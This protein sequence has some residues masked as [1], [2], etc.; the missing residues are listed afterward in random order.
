MRVDEEA[1]ARVGSIVTD[2]ALIESLKTVYA[3]HFHSS[4][5]VDVLQLQLDATA[6]F[7]G[8]KLAFAAFT[9]PD[10]QK[11]LACA[12]HAASDGTDNRAIVICAPSTC[13]LPPPPPRSLGTRWALSSAAPTA[14]LGRLQ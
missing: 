3:E 2:P 7:L 9:T 4:E 6:G 11:G 8:G 1:T 14:L 12:A 13:R 10:G 5:K